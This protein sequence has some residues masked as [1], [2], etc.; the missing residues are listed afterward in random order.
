MN[1]RA[2][3][4]LMH[5]TSLPGDYGIGSFG[6]AAYDFVDFLKETKQTYWQILPL[7]TTSYGDSPYQSFSAV[8][9]NTHFIDLDFL[10]R[11]KFLTKADV[12]GADFGSDP[13]FIDYAKVYEAR[14]PILEK[15]VKAILADKKEAKKFE[16]FNCHVINVDG[17]DFDQLRAAL[18]EARETKGMPTVIVAKTIKGKGVSFMED[19]QGWHGVAP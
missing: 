2:S 19:Q 18:K 10:I 8:A 7:T 11:D 15:A 4:V 16:A 3:G 1:K 6:Q 17:H 14:R 9:G 5:I 12:K 13:E